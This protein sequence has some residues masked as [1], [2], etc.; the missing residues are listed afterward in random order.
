MPNE[1]KYKDQTWGADSPINGEQLSVNSHY[2]GQHLGTPTQA[3]D[4]TE[5]NTDAHYV[6][7][8]IVRFGT[9]MQDAAPNANMPELETATQEVSAE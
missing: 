2:T 9:I 5:V 8:N 6:E 4:E 3:K 7:H 1:T